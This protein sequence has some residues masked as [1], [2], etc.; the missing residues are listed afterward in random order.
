[1]SQKIKYSVVIPAYSE[2]TIIESS[3]KGVAQCLESDKIRNKLTEVIVVAADGPDNTAELV[4]SQRKLFKNL[5]L[6]KPGSKVGKGR[7]VR[8]GV[9]AAKGNYILFL[10][11][12]MATPP[13]HIKEAFDKIEQ[14]G[15]DLLIADRPLNKIHNTLSRKVVS[16]LSNWIIRILAT[17]GI[18]DTQCGFKVFKREVAYKLFTPLETLAWGFDVEVLVRARVHGYSIEFLKI[19]DW[20][21]PKEDR[22]GLVGESQLHAYIS[23]MVELIK[24]AYKRLTRYYK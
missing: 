1:M 13:H 9:L 14:T 17:P 23:T 18:K 6:I 7:D 22:Q 5:R 16:V 10:D 3:L 8:A 12:D 19:N 11:A 20:H 2:A 24:I 21:D 4:L 15:A